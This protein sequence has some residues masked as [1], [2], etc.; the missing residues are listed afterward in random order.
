VRLALALFWLLGLLPLRVLAALGKGLGMLVYWLVRERRRVVRTNLRLCFP[1]MADADR[2]KL[3]RR[4]FRAFGRTVLEHSILWW[5]SEARIRKLVVFEGRENL[6]GELDKPVIVLAPHFVGLDMGGI[7]ISIEY[8][9]MSMYSHQKNPVLDKILLHGRT[10]FGESVLVSRQDGLRPVIRGL[11]NR[12]AFFYLPDMDLGP[13]DSLFVPFFGVQT[14]TVAGLS[15][16]A[17]LT[18]ARVVPCITRQLPG[19][20][21]YV[22]RF[23]PAWENF[24][25]ASVEDDT[26]RMNAFIEER[27]REMPEQYYWLHKRFKTR[28]PGEARFY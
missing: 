22:T 12:M 21:G 14:A 18:G 25:G 2:E 13:K 5:G 28:P 1:Q 9:M 15:R 6:D 7:R 16:L 11:R 17:R 27:V 3:S 26:A 23:Y 4:H 20:G 10:R 8:N 19:V 24:P